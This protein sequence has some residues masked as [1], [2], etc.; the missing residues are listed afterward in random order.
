MDTNAHR[1]G[2]VRREEPKGDL[3]Q[4]HKTWTPETGEQGISNRPDDEGQALS[5]AAEAD[6][7]ALKSDDD[8]NDQA[9][10]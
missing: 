6:E 5:D 10:P 9:E 2:P 7:R 4:G 1:D 8:D 3:G